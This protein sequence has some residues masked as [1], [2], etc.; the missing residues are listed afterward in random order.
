M[1][2]DGVAKGPKA[3]DPDLRFQRGRTFP[4]TVEWVF[5]RPSHMR[6]LLMTHTETVW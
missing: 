1:K 4:A 6:S 2:H 5:A 3:H